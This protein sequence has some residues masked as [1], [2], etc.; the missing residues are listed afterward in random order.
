MTMKKRSFTEGYKTYDTSHGYGN[1]ANWEQSF[2]Q[3]LSG[4]E[5]AEILSAQHKTP[6]EIL[7][8]GAGATLAEIKKAF[9]KLIHQWH[10]DKNPDQQER[11]AEESKIIIAA[12]QALTQ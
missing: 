5:A 9:R 6:R 2:Q 8:V 12:Y 11:A 4:E 10:P 3:R 7:G 1:R